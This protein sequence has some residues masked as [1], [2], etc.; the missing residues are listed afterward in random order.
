VPQIR[1]LPVGIMAFYGSYST[2]WGPIFA[3]VTL[4]SIPVVI[5]FLLLSRQFIAGLTAGAVKG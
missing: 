2:Q 1:T 3:A 5:G 4:A